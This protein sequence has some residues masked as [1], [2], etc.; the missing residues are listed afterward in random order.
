MSKSINLF[1]F[2]SIEGLLVTNPESII[3][4]S[5]QSNRQDKRALELINTLTKQKIPFFSS[6]RSDL[7]QMAKGETHQGVISEV[8][9]PP[10][11]DEKSLFKSISDNPSSPLI[12]VLDSIQDPRNLGACLRSANAAGVDYVVI[13]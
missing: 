9:L 6:D 7:D 13:N 3:K 1:G 8:I 5:I 10:L 4:V 12:L 11:L 2:H